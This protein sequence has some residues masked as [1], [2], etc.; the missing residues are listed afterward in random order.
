MVYETCTG[1]N[2]MGVSGGSATFYITWILIAIIFTAIFWSAYFLFIKK[3]I[4]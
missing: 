3:R 4:K 2:M 1:W